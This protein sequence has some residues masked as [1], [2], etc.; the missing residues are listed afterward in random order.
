MTDL[1]PKPSMSASVTVDIT[2]ALASITLNRPPGNRIHFG[3]REELRDAVRR[4]ATSQAKCLIV[5]AAGP[6]FCLGGDVRDW[7]GVP[8][9]ILRPK[10]A[11]FA[12]AL[13][14]LRRLKI[15]TLAVVQGRCYGGG[16]ELALSCDFIIASHSAVFCFP[17]A[18][19]GIL[20]LQGGVMWL[21]QRIGRAKA[22][23][24]VL[25]CEPVGAE[26]MLHWNVI[27]RL[28]DDT[29]LEAES[30]S[31]AERLATVSQPACATTK[32]LLHIWST[33][34]AMA[35]M[36]QWYDASM[37]LFDTEE[38]QNTLQLAAAA[39]NR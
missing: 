21:A 27:N 24:L 37:P 15:P 25:L 35:A 32:Q 23:E 30:N 7:P 36:D 20:T 12:E 4:V 3:M 26:Q 5:K 11:V 34:G 38:I 17:E 19:V 39:M 13:E 8:S 10:I 33:S 9:S 28:A 14:E 31:F 18:G 29:E 2:G 16:F 1:D 22:L 6:D